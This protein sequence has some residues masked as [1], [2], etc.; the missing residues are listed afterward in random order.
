V[1]FPLF[2]QVGLLSDSLPEG[3]YFV[4]KHH[5]AFEISIDGK[6]HQPDELPI[7]MDFTRMTFTRYSPRPLIATLNPAFEGPLEPL[8]VALGTAEVHLGETTLALEWIGGQ[9]ALKRLTRRN[10]VYPLDVRFERAF[11]DIQTLADGADLAGSFEI[12]G[13]P[14]TG[15]IAG[16]YTVE[17]RDGHITI[18]MVPARGWLPRP[19]K[20]ALH[21][22]YTVAS[23]FRKWPTTYEWTAHIHAQAT[24]A[25]A[26]RSAWRRIEG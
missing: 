23:V 17:K 14:S 25:Y 8:D 4:R 11:P 7:P 15:R 13:H 2:C 9:P 21:F 20:A 5:T 3:L 26:M 16:T 12:E 22:L 19:T 1:H 18:T 10:E 24:G 6:R